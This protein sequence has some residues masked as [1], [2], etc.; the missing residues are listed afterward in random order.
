MS[1]FVITADGTCRTFRAGWYLRQNTTKAPR[2][3]YVLEYGMDTTTATRQTVALVHPDDV[4]GLP[5]VYPEAFERAP[6]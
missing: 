2:D 4:R 5:D 6:A 1:R 3:W